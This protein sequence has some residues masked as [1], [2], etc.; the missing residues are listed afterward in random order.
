MDAPEK[1]EKVQNR[2]TTKQPKHKKIVSPAATTVETVSIP[3]RGVAQILI[4]HVAMATPTQI[5]NGCYHHPGRPRFKREA[6]EMSTQF[7][8]NRI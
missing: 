4:S 3:P 2:Q 5:Q 6:V 1:E 7:N 8:H